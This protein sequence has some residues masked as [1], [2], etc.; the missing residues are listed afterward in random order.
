MKQKITSNE[1]RK[2]W[3]RFF[4]E[5]NHLFLKSFSLIPIDDS[6]LLWINAGVTPLKA[7]FLGKKTA[8]HPRLVTIQK[9]IRTNDVRLV[10][11]TKRHLTFFEML[12]NFSVGDYFKKTALEFAFKFLT[13]PNYLNLDLNKL[14]FTIFKD[15]IDAYNILIALKINKNHILKLGKKTNFWEIGLGPCGPSCEIFY[16]R[17]SKYDPKNIGIEL[18]KQDIEN[19]RYLE[20]WNIVFSEFNQTKDKNIVLLP[21]K[22][23]DTGA[24]L[25]RLAQVLQNKNS[26]YE[27]D[28]FLGLYI[29]LSKLTNSKYQFKQNV[30]LNDNVQKKINY[31][32]IVIIDHLRAIVF[33][34]NE[35]VFVANKNRG[36]VIKKLIRR[37]L[38]KGINLNFNAPFLYKLVHF[39]IHEMNEFYDDLNKNKDFIINN[40]YNE[41]EKFFNTLKIGNLKLNQ[42]LKKDVLDEKKAFYL[43]ESFGLP[44]SLINQIAKQNNIF[45]T[46]EKFNAIFLEN[47]IKTKAKAKKHIA[48]GNQDLFL[49]NLNL[50]SKF[51]GYQDLLANKVKILAIILDHKLKK[52]VKNQKIWLVVSKTPFYATK[53]GQ[54]HDLGL[55]WNDNFKGKVTNVFLGPN[56]E[57]IHEVE[58]NGIINV[59]ENVNLKVFEDIRFNAQKNHSLT[60]LLHS[61]LRKVFDNNVFQQGSFNNYLGLHLD[62]SFLK[63][64]LNS[65]NLNSSI[66]KANLLAQE[67]I[68]QKIDSE[69]IF[70]DYKSAINKYH[71]LAF[72]KD[73]YN[74]LKNVRIVKF[75][76]ES[77]ELCGGTHVKNTKEIE[78]CLITNYKKIGFNKLRIYAISTNEN[79]VKEI[80]AKEKHYFELKLKNKEILKKL[81]LKEESFLNVNSLNFINYYF[82]LKKAI[83]EQEDYFIKL[84]KILLQND[85]QAKLLPFLNLKPIVK[86][87]INILFFNFKDIEKN[88]INKIL[89]FYKRKY[90]QN[91]VI[92]FLF[93]DSKLN[94]CKLFLIISK[95]LKKYSALNFLK[96]LKSEK[97][98]F[99]GGGNLN[100]VQIV[101]SN[102]TGNKKIIENVWKKNFK[103]IF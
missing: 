34:L 57:H 68:D 25:E 32:F 42:I 35:K 60:H 70:T 59:N 6:S 103:L 3:I 47:Q 80:K 51:I 28:L 88:L 83:K 98:L 79:I 65:K 18:L 19:D 26:V 40:L 91:T 12:G 30:T 99:K 74:D 78:K 44:F 81:N 94:L 10:A 50:N 73:K 66:L 48:Y 39:L 9:A 5:N 45:L 52:E 4:K 61:Q 29:Q 93:D 1:I 7:F 69:I 92:L 75:K 38:E 20:I 15:D 36:Y 41:E 82:N 63:E 24:G 22:N 96:T 14:Y 13:A 33:M 27:T 76:N 101:F 85:A 102:L 90:I 11:K 31:Y 67:L 56:Q 97:L 71:A 87:K 53:G 55:I 86:N 72:F 49:Q 62:V 23:I 54:E 37:A 95:D 8:P 89:N 16:D 64:N 2:L 58:I 100:F 43:Y 46:K 21:R 77:I 17:G 84:K